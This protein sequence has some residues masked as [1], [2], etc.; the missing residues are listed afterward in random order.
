MQVRRIGDAA[1]ARGMTDPVAGLEHRPGL[2]PPS[3]GHVHVEQHP[4]G[5]QKF[6]TV[7]VLQHHAHLADHHRA[8]SRRRRPLPAGRTAEV[9][10][11]CDK[12]QRGENTLR[13]PP[14]M[15]AAGEVPRVAFRPRQRQVRRLHT[16]GDQRLHRIVERVAKQVTVHDAEVRQIV[17]PGLVIGGTRGQRA[18]Y[19]R[20][21]GV[22]IGRKLDEDA[23]LR[24]H[25][26]QRVHPP[27]VEADVER[28]GGDTQLVVKPGPVRIVV[29]SQGV[30]ALFRR[31]VGVRQPAAAQFQERQQDARPDAVAIRHH[32]HD[33]RRRPRLAFYVL[34][35]AVEQAGICRRGP[36]DVKI[37]V[38]GAVD[39]FAVG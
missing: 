18:L 16:I 19:T 10:L 17:E 13:A 33:L 25:Q 11:V 12:V 31:R 36:F 38:A 26:P 23:I 21:R 37:R 27:A 1:F 24:P 7:E 35:V 39:D 4:A 29:V 6:V 28:V 14:R 34:G 3:R 9:A 15:R 2:D 8:G 22:E 32:L 5:P 20:C 30:G